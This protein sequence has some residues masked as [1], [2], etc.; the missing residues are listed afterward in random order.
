VNQAS[1]ELARLTITSGME[2]QRAAAPLACGRHH[3]TSLGRQNPGGSLIHL[4]E[5]D[6]LDASR[7]QTDA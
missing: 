1:R 7:E 4:A 5:E 3:V 2:R 6:A